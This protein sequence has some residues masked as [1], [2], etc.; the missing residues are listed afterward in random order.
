[1]AYWIATKKKHN[2]SHDFPLEI[3]VACTTQN[4]IRTMPVPR[5]AAVDEVETR[6]REMW[7]WNM[8]L[9][10]KTHFSYIS[11]VLKWVYKFAD[12]ILQ[13]QGFCWI[14]IFESIK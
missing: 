3:A 13:I 6:G 12:Y 14:R 5:E 10:V 4:E 2:I 8:S 7:V 1:M 9:I 11:V